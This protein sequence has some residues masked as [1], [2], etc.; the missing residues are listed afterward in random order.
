MVLADGSLVVANKDIHR[1]PALDV[2]RW[3]GKQLRRRDGCQDVIYPA[4]LI[5]YLTHDTDRAALCVTT[6]SGAGRCFFCFRP[7]WTWAS[8]LPSIGYGALFG[9]GGLTALDVGHATLY[10]VIAQG[11]SGGRG[12]YHP[13]AVGHLA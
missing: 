11:L 4:R 13:P 8:G 6:Q 10:L 9:C 5:A 3:H 1:G 2:P 12:G 7:L